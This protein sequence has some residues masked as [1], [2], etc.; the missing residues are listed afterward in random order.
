MS[1]AAVQLK[2]FLHRQLSNYLHALFDKFDDAL[3]D[4]LMA[5]LRNSGK[6]IVINRSGSKAAELDVN[7]IAQMLESGEM[8]LLENAQLFDKALTSI[9]DGL[10]KQQRVAESA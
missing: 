9:I 1:A 8:L 5:V 2:E 7:E 10:R 3:F 6:R 4:L